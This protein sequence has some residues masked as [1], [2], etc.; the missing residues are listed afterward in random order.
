MAAFSQQSVDGLVPRDCLKSLTRSLAN[1]DREQVG[2]E[3]IEEC[4]PQILVHQARV[5]VCPCLSIIIWH[6]VGDESLPSRSLMVDELVGVSGCFEHMLS[7]YLEAH[8]TLVE[9]LD[10]LERRVVRGVN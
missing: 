3:A 6:L 5:S 4:L 7:Q 10:R 1:L 2:S 8:S 9:G